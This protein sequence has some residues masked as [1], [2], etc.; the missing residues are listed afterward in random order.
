MFFGGK[1]RGESGW[2][3]QPRKN[4]LHTVF[5][6]KFLGIMGLHTPK[7][8]EGLPNLINKRGR[9][10]P[11]EPHTQKPKPY[12]PLKI[13]TP[14]R[15]T[16]ETRFGGKNPK[17]AFRKAGGAEGGFSDQNTIHLGG[18]LETK[19]LIWLENGF[20]SGGMSLDSG[21]ARGAQSRKPGVVCE[22]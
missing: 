2:V 18:P 21:K 20:G 22:D 6:K 4:R 13:L 10:I 11:R 15:K 14:L 17:G 16:H 12:L 8:K 1:L 5:E 7:P 3:G 19:V 9:S